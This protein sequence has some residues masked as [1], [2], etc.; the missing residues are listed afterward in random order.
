MDRSKVEVVKL[1][2]VLIKQVCGQYVVAFPGGNVVVIKDREAAEARANRWFKR[3]L[4]NHGLRMGVGFIDW[5]PCN[6]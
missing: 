5:L 6:S 2:T 1:G 4:G 3:R